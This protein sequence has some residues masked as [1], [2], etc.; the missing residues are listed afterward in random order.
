MSA[1][2]LTFQQYSHVY[3]M[4]VNGGLYLILGLSTTY[5]HVSEL[6]AITAA[7]LISALYKSPHYPLNL[8][9]PAVPSLVVAW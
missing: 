1:A 3:E 6:Q 7:L 2:W 9:Q 8:F 4:T 5:T